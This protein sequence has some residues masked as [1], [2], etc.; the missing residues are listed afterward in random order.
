MVTPEHRS[1]VDVGGGVSLSVIVREARPDKRA[2]LLVHGLASNARL[3]DG[4]ADH[5]SQAGHS[6]VAVDLRGH[7]RSARPDEGYDFASVSGDLSNVV[8]AALGRPVVVAGQSWGGNVAIEFAS[9]Y[10]DLVTGVA[11]I[12]GGFIKLSAEFPEWSEAQRQ[13]APPAFPG[14]TMAQ[15]RERARERFPDWPA[16][17]VEGQLANFEVDDDGFVRARLRRELHMKILRHMWEHDPDLTARTVPVPTLVV[18]V[19]EER[20]DRRRRVEEFA[21]SFSVAHVEWLDAHHD[22]HAQHPKETARLLMAFAEGL[23]A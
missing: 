17:G 4:V 19:D 6:S 13:L 21:R 23:D 2:F 8:E 16:R 20:D 3:W 5:L 10:P 11:C 22:V 14:M 12:D 7:G 1:D 9:R 18:A 15:L